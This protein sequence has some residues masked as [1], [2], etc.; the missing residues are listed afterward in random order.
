MDELIELLKLNKAKS[1]NSKALITSH[2]SLT[3]KEFQDQVTKIAG[4]LVELGIQKDDLIGILSKNNHDTVELIFALWK[5]G[6]IPLP[7]NIRLLPGEVKELL[8]F[9]NCKL[10]LIHKNIAEEKKSIDFPVNDY[11]FKLDNI[12]AFTSN[13]ALTSLDDTALI[14]FTSGSTG[15]PKAVKLSFNNLISSAQN[16]NELF[17]HREGDRWLASLPFY[18]IGGFSILV[19]SVLSGCAVII[20]DNLSIEAISD[21]VEHFSPTHLS[22]VSTQLKRLIELNIQPGEDLRLTLLGGGFLEPGLVQK[23]IDAGWKTCKSYGSTETASFITALN[24]EDFQR[25]PDSSGKP[26]ASNEI[27]ILGKNNNPCSAMHSGEIVVKGNSTAKEYLNDPEES[28]QRFV[29]GYYHTGDFGILDEDGYLYVEARRND[30]IISGGEN[31]NPVEVEKAIA[32]YEKVSEVCVFGQNDDEW[33]EIVSAVIVSENTF[34]FPLEELKNYLTGK[35]AG[36]KH[37]RRIYFIEELPK[38]ELG[39]VLKEKVKE[40]IAQYKV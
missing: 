17:K 19:R 23:S 20:P 11:P 31:I 25:K 6:A 18:H 9:V 1:Y 36:Y 26:L 30:L 8:E 29:N 7:V 16:A 4:K 39:K 27:L 24:R 32:G 10:L 3:Y 14:L 34:E 35:L 33:G 22:L 37:P 38:T 13:H 15:K 12:H 28:S 40:L 2:F 21:S 5:I